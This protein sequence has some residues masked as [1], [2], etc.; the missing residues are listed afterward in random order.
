MNN[1]IKSCAVIALMGFTLSAC[2]GKN[3][4]DRTAELET[5]DVALPEVDSVVLSNTFP[6]YLSANKTVDVVGR[7]NGQL[8]SQNY[9]NGEQAKAG[10]I[11]FIIESTSYRDAVEQAKAELATAISTRDYADSHYKAVKKALESDAVS[12]ME[13]IQAESSLKQAEASIKNARAALESAEKMLSYCTVRAPFSGE[14]SASKLDIGSYIG[15]EGSPVTLAQI[16]D[17]SMMVA[18]FAIDDEQYMELVKG[19]QSRDDVNLKAVPLEFSD[20]LPH[21]YTGDLS[22]ISPALNKSTGTIE[23][24]CAIANKYNELKS[25]MFVQVHLPYAND[26]N[27]ILVKD[28]SIGSDQ[29]GKYLYVIND[30]NKVVYTSITVGDV[31][32]DS[33][34]VVTSGINSKT[35]YVTKALLKVRDGMEVKP[36]LVK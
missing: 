3:A 36:R 1:S 16:Y 14:V 2:G 34:R 20:T 35:K 19:L 27:A 7:V 32:N 13:V 28:A 25:G 15:G 4:T 29:L 26:P 30:S 10:D 12:K 5:V 9:K 22:Y 11:L 6:G 8:L 18:H 33:M 23:L 21:K 17:N 31:Y 24:Q